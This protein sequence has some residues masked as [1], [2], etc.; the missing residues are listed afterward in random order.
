MAPRTL[1]GSVILLLAAG[2]LAAQGPRFIIQDLGVLPNLPACSA[3]ALSQSGDVV[4]YCTGS[5]NQNLL[6][7]NPV[8]HVFLY[9]KGVMTDLN[10][11]GLTTPVPTGV[12][13]SDTVVGGQVSTNSSSGITTATPFLYENGAFQPVPEQ[14]LDAMPLALNDSSQLVGAFLAAGAGISSFFLD[15]SAY[16]YRLPSGP[17]TK[18]TAIGLG[19]GVSAALSIDDALDIGGSGVGTGSTNVS[20]YLESGGGTTILR[21]LSPYPQG[22]ITSVAQGDLSFFPNSVGLGF[23][24]DFTV[25]QDPSAAA[26]AVNYTSSQPVD[27]GVLPG[28]LTSMATSINKSGTV[29]GFASTQPP[30]FILHLAALFYAPSGKYQAFIYS[31]GQMYN[32]TSQLV[33]GAG[34]QLSFANQINDAG[35]IVGSGLYTASDGSVL[36]HAF[37][38]TPAPV[39]PSITGIVGAAFS[40]PAVTSISPNGIFTIFG[41]QLATGA[42]A[43]LT[44][45]DIVDNQLPTDLGGTCVESGSTKWGLFYVSSGQINALAGLLPSSGTVP[46]AV[47][48]NCDSANPTASSVIN[49]S[50]APVAPEFLYFLEN[51]NGQNP[52]AAI[53]PN[54]AYVGPPGLIAGATF[55]PAKAGDVLTAFGVGWGST[56]SS[57]TPGTIATAA[58]TLADNYSLTLG[59][60]PVDVAYA[61]LTPGF[62][63]LY[64]IDFT[65]PLGLTAGN[66]PL[67][68]TVDGVP[69]EALAYIA[70]TN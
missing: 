13:N 18:L 8:T 45:A 59:G 46:L 42:P 39:G 70:L 68:L 63:G 43:P 14:L 53:E 27:L 50:V 29:V 38:L 60:R 12:N 22:L 35:Q 15:S 26:H 37:L 32:L 55:T 10:V 33:N 44:A 11:R 30:D 25:Q 49:V 58:A 56:T 64:Q 19:E 3:T 28:T 40:T 66:Q 57:A 5:A 21:L 20:P 51:T 31:G 1:F 6:T 2:S 9:S 17:L 4:G 69:T 7:A 34:W 41:S 61:G 52:V 54:G 24:L 48:T 36:Q 65:V 67:V 23:S 47:V 16:L 62:A